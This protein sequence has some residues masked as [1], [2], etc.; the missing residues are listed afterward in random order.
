MK[1]YLDLLKSLSSDLPNSGEDS[2]SWIPSWRLMV[3][4][5]QFRPSTV[6]PHIF[7]L[8]WNMH[9]GTKQQR[10]SKVVK[11]ESKQTN[12][13]TFVC[14]SCSCR[15]CAAMCKSWSVR[16][17]NIF[18]HLNISFC[19]SPFSCSDMLTW[20]GVIYIIILI[21]L[22]YLLATHFPADTIKFVTPF[23]ADCSCHPLIRSFI[24]NFETMEQWKV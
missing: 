13:F 10:K 18:Q 15:C 16:R 6:V 17:N 23:S 24:Q 8:F 3:K 12:L 4:T 5:Q 1:I 2:S 19:I 22:G 7:S 20:E 11:L 21:R 9:S 14:F